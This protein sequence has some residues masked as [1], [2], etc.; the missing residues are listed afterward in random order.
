M[1][2]QEWIE[3]ALAR[4]QEQKK[5]VLSEHT[6]KVNE[7][8]VGESLLVLNQMGRHARK[9]DSLSVVVELLPFQQYQV[10]LDKLGQV[11][12]RNRR[13]IGKMMV[14]EYRK[15]PHSLPV[16]SMEPRRSVWVQSWSDLSAKE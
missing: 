5:E 10:K 7:L 11:S 14:L 2:T 9:W 12:L 1:L 4:R 15:Q 3:K 16:V 8:K 13:L 6:K